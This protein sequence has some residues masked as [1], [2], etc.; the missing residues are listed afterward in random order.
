MF[1]L[2]I[3]QKQIH[4]AYID[5]TRHDHV[6]DMYTCP[7]HF[8]AHNIITVYYKV[9]L[10]VLKTRRNPYGEKRDWCIFY[11]TCIKFYHHSLAIY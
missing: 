7:L 10:T 8:T 6:H 9:Y 1:T 5:Q 11:N 2:L 4:D 3:L